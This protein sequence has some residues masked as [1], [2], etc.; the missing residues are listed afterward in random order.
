MKISVVIPVYNEHERIRE[1]IES[2]LK[3][4]KKPFEVIV[5]D[6]GSEDRTA[7]I[8]GSFPGVKVLENPERTAAAGRNVGIRNAR[9]EI[10]AFTDG[11][12]I[13]DQ[14]WLSSIQKC[15][16]EHPELDGLRGRIVPVRT[17]NRYEA[18]WNHLAWELLMQFG[19]EPYVIQERGLDR[20][21]ITANCAYRRKMLCK[22]KGF[23]R[24]FGNNAEDVDLTWRVL[25]QGATLMYDPA[26]LVYAHGVTTLKGIARKSFRNGISSSKLQKKY[27]KRINYDI[28]I[29]QM[30]GLNLFGVLQ[31]K[32]DAALNVVELACHLQGKYWGSLKYKVINI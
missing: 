11:D 3:N 29:Y 20:S 23:S 14:N 32:Q 12:C 7:E 9:G 13:V 8:A 27:G 28:S 30:L 24:W 22:V 16:E 21:L 17:D 18:Y 26:P 15:F 6:G 4:T 25:D 2:I 5:A 19:D 31:G 1:C 10:I